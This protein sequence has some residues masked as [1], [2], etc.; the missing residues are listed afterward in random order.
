MSSDDSHDLPTAAGSPRARA[1][2]TVVD[3]PADAR[4]PSDASDA[5]DVAARPREVTVKGYG[6]RYDVRRELGAGGMGV[7]R[8][9]YDTAIGREV[10]VKVML[11]DAAQRQMARDRF[12]REAQV[13]AQLEHPGIVPVYDLGVTPDGRPYFSM[14]RVRGTTL[15][16]ALEG[17]RSKDPDAEARFGRGKLLSVVE[18]VF[19]TMAYAHS[20]GVVHRDLKPAN[21]MLGD[22]GEVSVLD[23]GIAK[24]RSD[25]DLSDPTTGEDE[26]I[27][28]YTVP[29]SV[30]GTA[31]YM[32]PEQAA[33]Q[34]VDARADVYTLGAML[35]EVITR[36]PLHRGSAGD[37]MRSTLEGV[38]A[39]PSARVDEDVPAELDAICERAAKRDPR[40][41]HADASEMLAELRAFLH[42]ARVSELRR[43]VAGQHAE[44]ARLSLA[45]KPSATETTRVAALRELGAAAVLDPD[46]PEMIRMI[47]QLLEPEP[48]SGEL[49]EDVSR[50]LEDG[51]RSLA[52]R[53]AG[54]SALAYTAA[55]LAIP[56]LLWMGV[57][58]WG[59]LGALASLLAFAAIGATVMW[60]SRRAT[61]TTAALSLPFAFATVSLL[62]TLFAPFFLVPG[63][64]VSTAVAFMVSV[65]A[66]WKMRGMINTFAGL[67]V[68]VPWL[69]AELDVIPRTYRFVDGTIQLL[70]NLVEF[71]AMPTEVLVIFTSLFVVY[72]PT[73]LVG[74]AVEELRRAER[75]RVL[76]S[77]RLRSMLPGA[78]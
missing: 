53:A 1:A 16:A 28:E 77:Q 45:G 42:G 34:E 50:E 32:S 18:R 66:G 3:E 47:E 65:R 62:S 10:A 20:R 13:Q 40:Q 7:V 59:V 70:P 52:S 2:D 15:Q 27:P 26:L 36:T 12:L 25:T 21:I 5:P 73:T 8:L 75:R 23:W 11:D 64:A 35:F 58:L 39:R 4:A 37:R 9:A 43:E 24:L 19:E 76:Q 71:P 30:V 78:R 55:L 56:I 14:K 29:G 63:L 60:R 33:G 44:A 41:R 6:E 17:L 22:F 61:G 51:R 54:R 49:P 69:L 67:A 48:A 31:G 72:I 38:D 68:G 46:N 74:R 57:R